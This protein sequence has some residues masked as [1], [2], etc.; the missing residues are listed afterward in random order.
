MRILYFYPENPLLLSQGNHTRA[1]ALLH[2]FKHRN[3]E[4]DFVSEKEDIQ[5]DSKKNSDEQL[6]KNHY[7]IRKSE[8]KKHPLNYFFMF[9]LPNKIFRRVKQYN[10]VK[11]GQQHDFNNILKNNS[12]DY[13]IISYACWAPLIKNNCYTKNAKLVVDTHDF[14][15]AQFKNDKK[16]K[17]GKFF[18]AEINLLRLFDTVMVISTEEKYLFSQFIDKEVVLVTHALNN[19]IQHTSNNNFDIIYVASNNPHNIAGAKWFF[20]KV[21]PQLPKTIKIHVIG[22][23]IDSINDYPN[24]EKTPFI[25]NLS[26]C[27]LNAKIAICPMFSGTGVKIKVI[28]VLYHG[29]PVVCNE[30]AIDGLNNKTRNGCLVTNDLYEFADIINQLINNF[31]YFNEISIQAKEYCKTNHNKSLVYNKLDSIFKERNV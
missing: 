11:I 18:E 14:L 29:L 9:S 3:I 8:R 20:E 19:F 7:Y 28:E 6:I 5:L 22:G 23:V 21:Y 4:V 12:Y 1:L 15:T 10:R 24:V 30:K 16:F 31:E 27:Y 13:I 17:L 25:E 2:Y 26:D